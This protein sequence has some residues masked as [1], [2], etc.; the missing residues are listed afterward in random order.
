MVALGTVCAGGV[1][2]M[3]WWGVVGLIYLGLVLVAYIG[4]RLSDRR[5]AKRGAE[6]VEEWLREYYG[7]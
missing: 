7:P 4:T 2:I 3:P 5:Q 1:Q 6:E